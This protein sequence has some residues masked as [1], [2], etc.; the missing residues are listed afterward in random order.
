MQEDNVR[1]VLWFKGDTDKPIYT[2]DTRGK[3]KTMRGSIPA[4]LKVT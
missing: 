2:Y 3:S 4:P 1:L